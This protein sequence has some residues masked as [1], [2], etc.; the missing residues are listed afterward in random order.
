MWM[1][2]FRVRDLD[3]I[4]S[5]LQAAEIEV[6]VDPQRYPNGRFAYLDDP[7]GNRV[8]LWQPMD[9]KTSR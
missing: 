2:N 7:E 1:I 9:P 3:K 8:K 5:Q 6:K 4:A